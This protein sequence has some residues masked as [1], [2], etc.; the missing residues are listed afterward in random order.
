MKAWLEIIT[1]ST[2]Y[3]V[4]DTNVNNDIYN[5]YFQNRQKGNQKSGIFV[6]V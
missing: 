4:H 5:A 1:K 6:V 2:D 3:L